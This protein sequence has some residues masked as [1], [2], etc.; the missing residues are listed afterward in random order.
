MLVGLE[1]LTYQEVAK[2]AGI[3]IGTVMSRLS[4]GRQRLRDIVGEGG[5]KPAGVRTPN[6][7]TP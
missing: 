6:L 3:P 5:E 4:R 7:R 2:V 1:E